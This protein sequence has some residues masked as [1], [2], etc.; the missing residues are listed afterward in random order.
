MYRFWKLLQSISNIKLTPLVTCKPIDTLGRSPWRIIFRMDGILWIP[1]NVHERRML[2]LSFHWILPHLSLFLDSRV[3]GNGVIFRFYLSINSSMSFMIVEMLWALVWLLEWLLVKV[4]GDRNVY[5]QSALWGWEQ[6]G[7]H[8]VWWCEWCQ[9]KR[10]TWWSCDT[11]EA[12]ILLRLCVLSCLLCRLIGSATVALKDLTGDQSRS[13]PYKLISLLN[14][15]GQD[16]GVSFS[17]L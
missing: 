5:S 6:N 14:E 1:W 8:F 2:L 9:M 4:S 12:G 10:G 17:R 7:S 11:R 3:G 16:T 13:L 15:R